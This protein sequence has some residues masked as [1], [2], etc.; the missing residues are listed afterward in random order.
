MP[1]APVIWD[2]GDESHRAGDS[3]LTVDGAGLG[4]SAG[5]LWM[6]QNADRSGS[7]DQLTVGAWSM[8]QLTGVSIPGTLNNVPGTVYLFAKRI[9]QAW[10]PAYQFTLEVATGTIWTVT[11]T[12]G[13][14]MAGAAP[15]DFNSGVPLDAEYVGGYWGWLALGGAG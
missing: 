7:A 10:S 1:L 8:M 13:V 9:D 15:S 12:G 4:I 6:Y 3:G 2:F 14:V 5:E 11:P